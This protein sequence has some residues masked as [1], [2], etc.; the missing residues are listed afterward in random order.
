MNLRPLALDAMLNAAV[1]EILALL[2]ENRQAEPLDS[3]GF[4]PEDSADVREALTKM[5]S[6][7]TVLGE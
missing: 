6:I 2:C 7:P 3:F 1:A 4:S 5:A